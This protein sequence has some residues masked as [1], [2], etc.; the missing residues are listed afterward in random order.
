[1]SF[2]RSWNPKNHIHKLLQKVWEIVI[3]ILLKHL[4]GLNVFVSFEHVR[5]E[6][7]LR[8]FPSIKLAKLRFKIKCLIFLPQNVFTQLKYKWIFICT[9]C[10][11]F[12]K[13]TKN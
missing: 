10:L 11:T 7:K 12:R 3:Q 5:Y 13:L 1:M 2:K 9:Y 4:F 6:I 8:I